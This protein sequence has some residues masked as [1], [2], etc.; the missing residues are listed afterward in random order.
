ML[1]FFLCYEV[2]LFGIMCFVIDVVLM[3]CLWVVCVLFVE[4][5]GV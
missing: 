2:L 1:L 5:E 3:V 4:E